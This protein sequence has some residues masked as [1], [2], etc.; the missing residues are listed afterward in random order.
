MEDFN[1]LLVLASTRFER[2]AI[3]RKMEQIEREIVLRLR[4]FDQKNK[5]E[6]RRALEEVDEKAFGQ[7]KRKVTANRDELKSYSNQLGHD[8]DEY[9]S[10]ME[11]D[12]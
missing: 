1:R 4:P 2:E 5:T 9:L 3:G 7:I 10:T 12:T 8:F 6:S 11:E